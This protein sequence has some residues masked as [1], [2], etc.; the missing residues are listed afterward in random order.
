MSGIDDEVTSVVG[1]A[2][3]L[4]RKRPFRVTG[5]FSLGQDGDRR[6]DEGRVCKGFVISPDVPAGRP[7]C[8]RSGCDYARPELVALFGAPVGFD[9][10]D[11]SGPTSRPR[12]FAS[13]APPAICLA[14]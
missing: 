2:E 12:H 4:K 8:S 13:E 11:L 14:M 9:E 5:C 6:K 7:S 1:N 10:T 3:C